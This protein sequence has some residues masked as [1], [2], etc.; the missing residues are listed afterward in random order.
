MHNNRSLRI[1]PWL[2]K[3]V[4]ARSGARLHIPGGS[5]CNFV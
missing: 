5:R 2:A 4:W 1:R 3:L